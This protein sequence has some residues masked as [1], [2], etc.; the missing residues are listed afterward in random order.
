MGMKNGKVFL[1]LSVIALLLACTSGTIVQAE[2]VSGKVNEVSESAEDTVYGGNAADGS[3]LNN[4]LSITKEASVNGS[5]YS[6]YSS[7]GEASGNTLKI[8]RTGTIYESAEGGY[9]NSGSGAVSGNKVFMESGEVVQSINSGS[10]GGSG[11]ATGNSIELSGGTVTVSVYGGV[12]AGGNAKG[13][14]VTIGGGSIDAK[15]GNVYG[16]VTLTSESAESSGNYLYIK[17]SGTVDANAYGGYS[18]FG[19]ALKNIVTMTGGTVGDCLYGGRVSEKSNGEASYNEV[20]ISGGTVSNDV[21]GGYSQN[22]DV[23]GNKVTVEGTATVKGTDYSDVYGSY[24][25]DGKASGNQVQ[26]T[27]GS[28]QSEISGAF[29]FKGDAINN[30][31]TISGGTV[32]GYASGGFSD[33]GAV[34]G[35]IITISEN[36]TIKNDAVG[37][38]LSEGTKGTSGNQ[39]IMTGGSVGGNLIGGYIMISSPS[40]ADNTVTL[41]GGSV[42][43]DVMGAYTKTNSD[44]SGNTATISGGT[45]SGDIYGAKITSG[46]VSNN[47]VTV[48][49]GTFGEETSVYGG[50]TEEGDA[51][52]NKVT[53][54]DVTVNGYAEGGYS[55]GGS[56]TGNTLAISGNS[57]V[58]ENAYG[59]LLYFAD[60]TVS[61]NKVL[62]SGGTVS[63]QAAGGMSFLGDAVEVSG[64]EITVTGGTIEEG[65]Y[66][67]LAQLGGNAS[68]NT[69]TISGGTINKYVYGGSADSGTA[70]N[71]T[72]NIY[73]GTFKSDTRLYGGFSDDSSGNT[74]NFYTKG[75]TVDKLGYFQNLSFYVPEDTTAGETILT[76]TSTADVSG[77]SIRASVYDSMKMS[78]G[79][80]ITLID[81]RS[82]LTAEDTDYGMMSGSS[83][84]TDAAFLRREVNIRKDGDKVILEVP[85]D[86]VPSLL[87]DTKLLAEAREASIETLWNASDM[88]AENYKEAVDAYAAGS[89][90]F[91]PYASIGGFDL[92]H[93]TGSYIDTAGLNANIGFARQYEREDYV[94]TLM[95]FFEYGRSNYT[96]HLDDGARADGDQHYTGAGV[97]YRRDRKDGLHYEALVRAGHLSG[98]FKGKI[99]G[100]DASYDSGAP[101][102]AAMAG[103]GKV[104]TRDTNSLD[105]YGKFFWTHLGS[106]NVR[107]DNT[108]GS[109]RYDFD[110]IDSYRTKLGVRWTKDI[111]DIGSCYAGIGW[112]YEFDSKARASYRSFNTPSPS[113]EG[114]SGFLELGWKSRLTKENPWGADVNV[115]GWAGKQRGVTYTLSVSRAF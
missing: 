110:S 88:A 9:V 23:I 39:A 84:V 89:G 48:T 65:V 57:Y 49:G 45:V 96:S 16:G 80:T 95:P 75:I 31:L 17:E 107:I 24:S 11:D 13:N 27:G 63:G 29:S 70:S 83:T 6:G 19:S 35:N 41:S 18:G 115:T 15:A 106:D 66:G 53:I 25:I 74:L 8:T 76:V 3:A 100:Y 10:T 50:Y 42:S 34:T 81:G 47:T 1:R 33:A 73:G 78:P 56:V 12:S 52:G 94:D 43:G 36:G 79:D 21:I 5:A 68:G 105:Y 104:V 91:M 92:R 72:V 54:Q 38:L 109:S 20:T 44:A 62:L 67:G 114:S 30:T 77:A 97:L 82:G 46:T 14:S 51:S 22:G 32:D 55:C 2:D 58:K 4:Q 90:G 99:A 61:G 71:N 98:D 102:I 93:E 37:G 103:L 86:S 40:N 69:V 87:S 26:M 59:G 7:N 108:L 101:Y 111:S 60:G 85:E 112:D 113:A 28:V 64:N